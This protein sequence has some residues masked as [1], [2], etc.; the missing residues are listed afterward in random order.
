MKRG[1]REI[2]R[3]E[4]ANALSSPTLYEGARALWGLL[5]EG[6][7]SGAGRPVGPTTT[8][9]QDGTWEVASLLSSGHIHHRFPPVPA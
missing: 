6:K 2:E 1:G 3:D 8:E 9:L 5:G 4:Q 7:G